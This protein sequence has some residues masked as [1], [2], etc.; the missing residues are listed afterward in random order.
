MSY[1]GAVTQELL[2][3]TYI[4]YRWSTSTPLPQSPYPNHLRRSY[5]TGVSFQVTNFYPKPYKL[6]LLKLLYFSLMAALAAE[7]LGHRI[8]A[9]N[10]RRS[11]TARN[12]GSTFERGVKVRF[13]NAW[14][15][16]FR[17]AW[18]SDVRS[19]GKIAPVQHQM[20]PLR[21]KWWSKL[22][23]WIV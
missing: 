1:T 8:L 10:V 22:R 19:R 15:N 2:H 16:L 9:W 7:S 17:T 5:Y 13:S 6:P 11:P 14:C 4:I 12:Y 20:Q 18:R 21:A 23:F 3:I